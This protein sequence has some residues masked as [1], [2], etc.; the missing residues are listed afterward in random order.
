VQLIP[1]GSDQLAGIKIWA[2]P[3]DRRSQL[4]RQ[5]TVGDGQRNAKVI[6][7]Y[8]PPCLRRGPFDR[9]APFPRFGRGQE[10]PNQP[11]ASLPMRRNAAGDEP[12][13]QMSSGGVGRGATAAALT[14]KNLPL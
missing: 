7:L 3:A 11:S 2:P 6:G 9:L 13:T 10:L 5:L 12:P 1:A 8:L 4:R 14:V